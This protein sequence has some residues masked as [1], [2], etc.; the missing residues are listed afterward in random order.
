[1]NTAQ[2]QRAI[3]QDTPPAMIS[4]AQSYL[5][6]D[7][8]RDPVAAE[9]WLLRAVAAEDAL[10]SPRAMGLLATKLWQ[11]KEPL[12]DADYLQMRRRVKDARGAERQTL[13]ELLKLASERQKNI[14]H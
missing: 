6:G 13:L 14:P 12:S 4:V 1:M 11:I 3:D 5:R 8:L 7:I 10:I 9:A 2:L